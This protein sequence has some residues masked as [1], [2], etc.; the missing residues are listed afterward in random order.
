M[1][2]IKPFKNCSFNLDTMSS[3]KCQIIFENTII[4]FCWY[5]PKSNWTW[6]IYNFI[7]NYLHIFHKHAL[8]TIAFK[9]TYW[10]FINC[11]IVLKSRIFDDYW[12]IICHY[13]HNRISHSKIISKIW[14]TDLKAVVWFPLVLI[15]YNSIFSLWNAISKIW[16]WNDN[17][18]WSLVFI[19][20]IRINEL[21]NTSVSYW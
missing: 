21:N 13:I 3:I 20:F 6:P 10:I 2:L 16:L 11:R 7:A 18:T 8:V 5:F 19:I 4:K 17:R 1:T 9:L 14:R 12:W 15:T